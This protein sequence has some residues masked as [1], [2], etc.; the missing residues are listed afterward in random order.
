[1]SDVKSGSADETRAH[2]NLV[3]QR[4]GEA[5]TNLSA[6]SD[7]HDASK[8]Q[9]PELSG[10]EGLRIRLADVQFGTPEYQAAL[11]E[12]RPVIAH[13]Y[14]ANDH[15]PEHY[16]DGV[17]GMSLL[18]VLEMLCDWKAAGERT[19]NG[20]LRQSLAVNIPRFKI[21]DQLATL[22]TNTAR[23]LGWLEAEATP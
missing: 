11:A 13:H 12:A 20:S 3:R 16:A 10:F 18:S 22:L 2:V 21:D 1:M 17:Y 4:I 14:A 19:K 6:R 7:A 9:E 5:I 8:L 15:H 23:E